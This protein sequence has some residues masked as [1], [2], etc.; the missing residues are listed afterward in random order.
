M[1]AAGRAVIARLL[2]L[3]VPR[4]AVSEALAGV[5]ASVPDVPDPA[6][7][8]PM[9]AMDPAEIRRRWLS[10][11]ANEGFRLLDAR[12]ALR[13]SDIDHLLVAGHAF[14]RVLGGPMHQAHRRGLLVLRRDL[15][16]FAGEDDPEAPVWTPHPLLDRLIARGL[17]LSDLDAL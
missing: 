6:L 8:A 7:P 14:P 10:A 17:R 3:G 11:L 15:R 2:A 1:G 4:R 9:R 13:P 5:G 12:V 16:S